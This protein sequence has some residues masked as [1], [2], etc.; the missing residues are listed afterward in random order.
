MDLSQSSC[1]VTAKGYE[2]FH[3]QITY[4]YRGNQQDLE[5]LHGAREMI[6]KSS[7]VA[8]GNGDGRVKFAESAIGKAVC[9]TGV[10]DDQ[11]TWMTRLRESGG[12]SYFR[13]SRS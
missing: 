8:A 4:N 10:C 6:Q 9:V 12:P 5:I 11:D 2:E 3:V 1:L 13:C 7:A